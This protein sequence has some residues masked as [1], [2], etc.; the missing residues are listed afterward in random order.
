MPFNEAVINSLATDLTWLARLPEL[1]L[2]FGGG[3]V[4]VVVE[5]ISILATKY[6]AFFSCLTTL[7]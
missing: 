4:V 2:L 1:D 5:G 7:L 3:A 6:E